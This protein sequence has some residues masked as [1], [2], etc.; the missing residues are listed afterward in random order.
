[1]L[2][3]AVSDGPDGI[4]F[5]HKI[6][7]GAADKSYGIHVAKMAGMPETV[8]AKA[9]SVLKSLETGTSIKTVQAKEPAHNAPS[10]NVFLV[11]RKKSE[12]PS[13]F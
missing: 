1:L 13:L 7:P 11:S 12:Q 8:V 5:M 10:P 9:E 6:R 3:V 2:N 4:V